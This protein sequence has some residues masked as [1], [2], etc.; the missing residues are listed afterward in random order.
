MKFFNIFAVALSLSLS[1]IAAFAD[2][3]HDH[4][5]KPVADASP[6][7]DKVPMTEGEVKKI[8]K[9]GGKVT[10]KHGEIKNLDMPAMTMVFRVKE[11]AMLDQLKVGDKINFVADKIDGKYAVTKFE[12]AK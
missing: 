8:D 10:I 3:G 11:A 12:M 4:G 7:A 9:D 1:P 5:K 2:P 6:P